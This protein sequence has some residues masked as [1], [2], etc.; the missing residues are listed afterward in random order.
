MNII[1]TGAQ[2]P[3]EPKIEAVK[4]FHFIQRKADD[5]ADLRVIF[6]KAYRKTITHIDG[7]RRGS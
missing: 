2:Q 7:G 6:H 1:V 5:E 3:P 4:F